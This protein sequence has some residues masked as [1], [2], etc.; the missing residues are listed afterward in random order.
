MSKKGTVS[1]TG[2]STLSIDYIINVNLDKISFK[3]TKK[4]I[5]VQG[6]KFEKLNNKLISV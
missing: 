5:K 6:F 1:K 3:Y 2:T 4:C